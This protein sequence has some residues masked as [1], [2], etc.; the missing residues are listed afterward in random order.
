M[1]DEVRQVL[2][3]GATFETDN[4]GVGAL[5]SGAVHVLAKRYPGARIDFLDY[6]RQANESLVR[7]E[8]RTLR[9]PLVNLRFSWKIL[10]PNNI[11]MLLMLAGLGRLLGPWFTRL[12]ARHNRWLKAVREADVAVALSGGDSF[13]DIYGLGRF[14]YVYLPQR[15]VQAL[16]V[17]LVMLPQTIGPFRTAAARHLAR[18]LLRRSHRVFARDRASQQAAQALLGDR[19]EPAR[20]CCDLGFILEPQAPGPELLAEIAALK[21]DGRALVGLNVSGLLMMG[22]Y[23]R[24]NAFGLSLDYPRFIEQTLEFLIRSKN[25]DV[26]LVPHVFGHTDES[27][28]AACMAIEAKASSLYPGRIACVRTRLDQNQI[29]HVIGQCDMLV[30]ARMHAC[31][32]ALSQAIPAVGIAYSDKFDG[33]FATVGA[34]ALVADARRSSGEQIL[35]LIGQTLDQREVWAAG[36]R[37]RMM[38]V[39]RE[40]FAVMDGVAR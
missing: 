29:K 31:I 9:V 37:D 36:L 26:L 13:S 12:A 38:Q 15:L 4:M 16:G 20:F 11:V 27:D 14:L 35:A 8:G 30:G 17:K 39:R 23:R 40:L 28:L 24:D 25:A 2:V 7:I 32:A 10:L 3:L 18:G 33:V 34:Q 1:Q 19:A 5:A 6:G 21:A 22:G